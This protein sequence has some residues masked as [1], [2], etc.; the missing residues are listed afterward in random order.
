M[1]SSFLFYFHSGCLTPG[2]VKLFIINHLDASNTNIIVLLPCQAGKCLCFDRIFGNCHGLC[3][4]AFEVLV[5]A[6]LDNIL[7]C[8]RISHPADSHFFLYCTFY[9][10]FFHLLRNDC[11]T[12]LCS[13]FRI[14]SFTL[15][16]YSCI[17]SIFVVAIC[18]CI[19]PA[20]KCLTSNLYSYFRLLHF[21][22]INELCSRKLHAKLFIDLVCRTN[23]NVS[24]LICCCSGNCLSGRCYKFCSISDCFSC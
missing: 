17:T 11:E 22:V 20:G 3:C 6:V 24:I 18:H 2:R 16:E 10:R 21:S 1:S 9:R 5:L 23:R 13:I 7:C 8:L 4:S 12:C 19:V 14:A 15:Y